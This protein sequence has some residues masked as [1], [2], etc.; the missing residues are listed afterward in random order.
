MVIS[1]F[2]KTKARFVL[3][4]LEMDL[5]NHYTSWYIQSCWLERSIW[6]AK[7]QQ[8][9]LH[10]DSIGY[11]VID[12]RKGIVAKRR[13]N[14]VY[15]MQCKAVSVQLGVPQFCTNE[16]PVTYNGSNLYLLPDSHILTEK[17]NKVT[18]SRIMPIVYNVDGIW[19]HN[20][21]NQLR[22][23]SGPQ[24]LRI[25]KIHKKSVGFHQFS[26]KKF[27]ENG[28]Y[29]ANELKKTHALFF[30]NR[31]IHLVN[32]DFGRGILYGTNVNSYDLAPVSSSKGFLHWAQKTFKQLLGP[33][34]FIT[35]GLSYIL[36][37][38]LVLSLIAA[39]KKF[40]TLLMNIL[41]KD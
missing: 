27:D 11:N 2:V 6:R 30:N 26:V 22:V 9:M 7:I 4:K 36:M 1:R 29:T 25:A 15:M 24:P 38:V 19:Y 23:V 35:E 28:L 41:S 3:R 18:C 14:L 39:L 8:L 10:Q 17:A 5:Y 32:E 31:D 21:G 40:K 34:S 13:G 20:D 33:F 16:I 12:E 37:V